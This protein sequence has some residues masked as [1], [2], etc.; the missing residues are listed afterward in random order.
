MRTNFY[1]VLARKIMNKF[2]KM[3][4]FADVNTIQLY[5]KKSV[6]IQYNVFSIRKL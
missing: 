6:S 3:I 4:K 1:Y 2:K 5:M